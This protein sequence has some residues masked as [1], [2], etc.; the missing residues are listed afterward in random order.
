MKEEKKDESESDIN[1]EDYIQDRVNQVLFPSP[2]HKKDTKEDDDQEKKDDKFVQIFSI[3]LSLT[4][5]ELKGYGR[6]QGEG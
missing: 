6:G 4:D 5:I 3:I 1:G 2:D